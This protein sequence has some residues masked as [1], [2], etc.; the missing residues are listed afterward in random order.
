MAGEKKMSGGMNGSV[1][2]RNTP[3]FLWQTNQTTRMEYAQVT[4]FE[5]LYNLKLYCHKLQKGFPSLIC[6]SVY[7]YY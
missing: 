1:L 5:G 6:N 4:T 3:V 7:P 2:K